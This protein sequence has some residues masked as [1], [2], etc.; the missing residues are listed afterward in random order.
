MHNSQLTL[1]MNRLDIIWM[2]RNFKFEWRM[3]FKV[4]SKMSKVMWCARSDVLGY[5][6]ARMR[7]SSINIHATYA[8]S[9]YT[10]TE[11]HVPY[12]MFYESE[13]YFSNKVYWN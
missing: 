10:N 2:L 4:T 9:S 1:K 5:V 8:V 11:I 7:W 12:L 3:D 13:S 6:D